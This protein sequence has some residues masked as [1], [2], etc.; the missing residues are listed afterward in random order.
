[1]T[2][3]GTTRAWDKQKQSP[4]GN[5]SGDCFC[6]KLKS[7]LLHYF[8]TYLFSNNVFLDHMKTY[9]EYRLYNVIFKKIVYQVTIY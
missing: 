9:S 6:N 8:Q 2:I 5:T 7:L 3:C 1:M 4:R